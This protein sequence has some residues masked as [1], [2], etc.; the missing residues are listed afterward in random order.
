V[1]WRPPDLPRAQYDRRQ[2]YRRR[3]TT[4]ADRH[5]RA[6]LYWLIG[7]ASNNIYLP[8]L[9]LAKNMHF[10]YLICVNR[11]LLL[12]INMP[13][14]WANLN[15]LLRRV[16]LQDHDWCSYQMARTTERCLML[17]DWVKVLHPTWHKYMSFWRRSSKLI[18]WLSTEKLKQTQKNQTRI[19]NK[20]YYNI[21][22][23][24]KLK[25]GLVAS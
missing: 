20:I 8:I 18:S 3:Q 24:K 6:K 25:P 10:S 21:K 15:I 5:K 1:Q 12:L 9:K 19:H 4:D 16:V 17:I 14:S 11:K 7:R 13:A 2:R 23:T 22:R